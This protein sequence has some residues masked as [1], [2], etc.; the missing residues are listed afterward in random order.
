VCILVFPWCHRA[1]FRVR[2]DI[3]ALWKLTAL[4]L[5][6]HFAYMGVSALYFG[7]DDDNLAANNYFTLAAF[8]FFPLDG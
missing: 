8:T 7:I 4:W 5:V 2:R 6:L 3:A 1:F